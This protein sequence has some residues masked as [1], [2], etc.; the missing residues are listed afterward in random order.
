[1]KGAPDDVP[2]ENSAVKHGAEDDKAWRRFRRHILR[3]IK[4]FNI[5]VRQESTRI[6]PY[7]TSSGAAMADKPGLHEVGPEFVMLAGPASRR[8]LIGQQSGPNS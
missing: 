8:D 2:E 1:M 6:P 7:R 4:D 3:S 5:L